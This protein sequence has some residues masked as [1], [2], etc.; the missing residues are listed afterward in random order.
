MD[1]LSALSFTRDIPDPDRV[2]P[3][4]DTASLG[5]GGSHQDQINPGA[6]GCVVEVQDLSQA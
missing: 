2:G 5:V 3:P 1:E 4:E 6:Q